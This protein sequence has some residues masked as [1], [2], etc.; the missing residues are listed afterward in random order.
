KYHSRRLS[1]PTNGFCFFVKVR[2]IVGSVHTKRPATGRGG[3]T[4]DTVRP[5]AKK[6]I[7]TSTLKELATGIPPSSTPR[8]NGRRKYFDCPIPI[9]R[10]GNRRCPNASS[11]CRG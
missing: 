5:A 4:N 8:S 6:T 3:R 7:V 1:R 9:P 2:W 10:A 11:S